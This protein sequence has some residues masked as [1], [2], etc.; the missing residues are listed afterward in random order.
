MIEL[1][2]VMGTYILA[3]VAVGIGFVGLV[4]WA[5]SGNEDDD[6]DDDDNDDCEEWDE[7]WYDWL[8]EQDE[9]KEKKDDG[10]R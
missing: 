1:F 4:V 6:D 8:K 5:W 2:G 7:G 9:M 10:D 3:A